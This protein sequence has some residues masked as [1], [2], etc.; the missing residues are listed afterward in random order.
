[1][2]SRSTQVTER[3]SGSGKVNMSETYF[4]LVKTPKEPASEYIIEW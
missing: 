4:S 3:F 1:M 2:R